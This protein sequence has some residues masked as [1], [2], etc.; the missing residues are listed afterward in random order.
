MNRKKITISISK[1]NLFGFLLIFPVILIYFLPY[2][3]LH[4]EDTTIPHFKESVRTV[5]FEYGAFG[6]FLIVIAISLVGVVLHEIIHGLCWGLFAKNSFKSI[7]FG[8]VWKMLTP[9]CHGKEPLQV[10]QYIF[11]AIMPG[12]ILGL[13][14]AIYALICDNFS[15][16]LF[17]IFFTFA[18]A[19]DIL[20]VYLLRK[21]KMDSL[22][23]DHPSEMGCY[24][25]QKQ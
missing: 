5:G 9:Y 21:E 1:A 3:F 2:Y 25:Y 15:I 24:I 19:G 7:S 17:G 18:A 20:I 16:L 8:V 22:V 10:N 4:F 13:L 12:I 23:Q 14:P 6:I 11:G